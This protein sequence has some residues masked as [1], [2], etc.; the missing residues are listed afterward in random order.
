MAGMNA[1]IVYS[2]EPEIGA[3]CVEI[4]KPIGYHSKF[5]NL[6]SAVNCNLPV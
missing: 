1:L 3:S 4:G 5:K 6:F 2:G